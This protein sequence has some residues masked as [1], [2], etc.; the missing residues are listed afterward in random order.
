MG[1]LKDF[2][3]RS[4]SI[5]GYKVLPK[6]TQSILEDKQFKAIFDKCQLYTMAELE[7]AYALYEATKY[8]VASG[9]PGD[10]VECGVWKGG[11]AMIIAHTLLLAGEKDRKIYLYDTFEGMPKPTPVDRTIV[12][13]LFA[14]DRWKKEQQNGY[15]TWCFSPLEE[16]RKNV[17]STGYPKKNFVF[18]KGKVEE[19]IPHTVPPSV[20]LLRLDTDFYESTKWELRHIYPLLRPGGILVVDDYGCWKGVQE[21]VDEYF[22]ERDL[23]IFLNRVDDTC[24]LGVKVE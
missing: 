18:I 20:A 1:T 13:C 16:V 6:Y 14:L 9:I 10:F 7:N 11:S 23:T 3:H 4:F 24:R 19:T 5:F 17:E 15:N 8:I 12:G 21:A 22:L 2:I